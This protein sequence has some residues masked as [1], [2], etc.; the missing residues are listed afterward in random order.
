M[1]D[2]H[3]VSIFFSL[4]RTFDVTISNDQDFAFSKVYRSAEGI[5]LLVVSLYDLNAD[6]LECVK[7]MTYQI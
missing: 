3:Y 7:S 4:E 6:E 1:V 2:Q 5:C